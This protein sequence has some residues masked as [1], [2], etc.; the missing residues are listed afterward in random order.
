MF[1]EEVP[2][3]AKVDLERLSVDELKARI[4]ALEQGCGIRQG[5]DFG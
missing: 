5:F 3:P 2:R 4:E 1:D